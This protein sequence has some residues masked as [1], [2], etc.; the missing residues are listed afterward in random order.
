[1]VVCE[2]MHEC[3]PT[4]LR[5]TLDVVVSLIGASVL[6]VLLFS[7]VCIGLTARRSIPL[8]V[9]LCQPEMPRKLAMFSSFIAV[10]VGG[11]WTLRAVPPILGIAR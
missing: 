3:V 6:A 8:C 10:V 9:R 11:I 5:V 7:I 2:C 4:S 1:M